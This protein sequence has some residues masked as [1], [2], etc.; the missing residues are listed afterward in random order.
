MTGFDC[1]LKLAH[2]CAVAPCELVKTRKALV[3]ELRS[4]WYDLERNKTEMV[5]PVSLSMHRFEDRDD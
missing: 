3:V 5:Q 4:L 2:H 1:L